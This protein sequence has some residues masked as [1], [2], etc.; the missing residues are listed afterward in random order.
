MSKTIWLVNEYGSIP[1]SGYAGRIFYMAKYL[2]R[3]G[4]AVYFIVARD[5]HLL[6][7]GRSN[8]K[9]RLVDGVNVVS[10]NVLNYSRARSWKR[11]LNWFI[12]G[13]QLFFINRVINNKPDFFFFFAS[14]RILITWFSV[15]VKK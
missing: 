4:F 9:A 13:I 10:I 2:S 8:P 11:I 12:F 1:E 14:S 6:N 5:H 3:M 15:L 7:V